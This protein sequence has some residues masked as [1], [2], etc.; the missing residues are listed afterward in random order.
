MCPYC[1]CSTCFKKQRRPQVLGFICRSKWHRLDLCKYEQHHTTHCLSGNCPG[2][3]C[4]AAAGLQGPLG[5]SHRPL[6]WSQRQTIRLHLLPFSFSYTH[7][8]CFLALTSLHV[9]SGS[10]VKQCCPDFVDLLPPLPNLPFDSF[11]SLAPTV[12]TWDFEGSHANTRTHTV[13]TSHLHFPCRNKL[14][15]STS[16]ATIHILHVKHGADFKLRTRI[17]WG[18]W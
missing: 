16:D 17:R 18:S 3:T 7:T 14:E 12:L 2:C 11:P 4:V 1:T 9:W 8:H 5:V 10:S 15:M 13:I 6:C